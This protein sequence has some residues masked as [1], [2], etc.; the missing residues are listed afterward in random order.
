MQIRK[1]RQRETAKNRF[2]RLQ[3][4]LKKGV[5]DA[6]HEPDQPVVEDVRDAEAMGSK[7]PKA[8]PLKRHLQVKR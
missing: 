5:D 1:G 4:W 7:K 8:A 2:D 3:E 6:R